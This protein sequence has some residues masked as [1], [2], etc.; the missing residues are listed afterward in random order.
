M[1]KLYK[2][3]SNKNDLFGVSHYLTVGKVYEFEMDNAYMGEAES[4][5]G[6]VIREFF[7]N[8]GHGQWE[9]VK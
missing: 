4:D 7:P 2:C 3:V 6:G 1:K 8:P 5:R 9:E